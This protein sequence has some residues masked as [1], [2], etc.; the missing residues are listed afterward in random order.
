MEITIRSTNGFVDVN[1]TS[2]R[3]WEGKTEDGII[4][5]CYIARVAVPVSEDQQK[6]ENEFFNSHTDTIKEVYS[7]RQFM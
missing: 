7:L 4:I 1:G 3:I 5:K 6:F 2:C